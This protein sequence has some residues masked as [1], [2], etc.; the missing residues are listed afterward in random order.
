M[1]RPRSTSSVPPIVEFCASACVRGSIGQMFDCSYIAPLGHQC[2]DR[3]LNFIGLAA[4]RMCER[5]PSLSWPAAYR[6]PVGRT[7]R[8]LAYA[9]SDDVRPMRLMCWACRISAKMGKRNQ[10]DHS[11]QL[12]CSCQPSRRTEATTPHVWPPPSGSFDVGRRPV[13]APRSWRDRWVSSDA[14]LDRG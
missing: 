3:R 2:E 11:E 7:R 14:R 8:H 13:V 6:F 12:A 10:I 1:D 9:K 5:A 4:R